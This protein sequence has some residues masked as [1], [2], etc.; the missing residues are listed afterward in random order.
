MPTH[1]KVLRDVYRD[2]Q[3]VPAKYDHLRCCEELAK[4][5]VTRDSSPTIRAL[6]DCKTNVHLTQSYN[7][8]SSQ[9]K[10]FDLVFSLFNV[11]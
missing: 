5:G 4:I 10:C 3:V 2:F 6:I 1:S 11:I 8:I 7:F 9:N